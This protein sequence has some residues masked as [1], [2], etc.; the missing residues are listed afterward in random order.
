M[1]R[2][3]TTERKYKARIVLAD[4]S[5]EGVPKRKGNPIHPR[6]LNFATSGLTFTVPSGDLTVSLSKK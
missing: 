6:F 4:Q 3:N 1:N 5:D 2:I